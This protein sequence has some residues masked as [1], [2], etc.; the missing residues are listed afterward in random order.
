[1]IE[2]ERLIELQQEAMELLKI[3]ARMRKTAYE[4]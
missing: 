1:M 2:A 3:F 4:G